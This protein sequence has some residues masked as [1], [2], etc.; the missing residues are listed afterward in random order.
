MK[1]FLKNKKV[2]VI[3]GIICACVVVILA[4]T[5]FG[6]SQKQ[7]SDSKPS[8]KQETQEDKTNSDSTDGGL[9]IVEPETD[10]E[11]T[12]IK[13]SVEFIAP[14]ED[15]T[16]DDASDSSEKEDTD[17]KD[18]QTTQDKTELDSETDKSEEKFLPPV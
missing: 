13:D 3:F 4:V 15:K 8:L 12:D 14:D 1:A 6:R 18:D 2:L 11:K 5:L 10:S 16:N 7:Q 17:E 9:Q